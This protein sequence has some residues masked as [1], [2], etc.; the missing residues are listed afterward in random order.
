MWLCLVALSLLL[1]FQPQIHGAL[2]GDPNYTG[3]L[4]LP[5]I[6]LADFGLLLPIGLLLISPFLVGKVIS[7]RALLVYGWIVCYGIAWGLLRETLF[8]QSR[9][10]FGPVWLSAVGS[11][12]AWLRRQAGAYTSRCNWRGACNQ[13]FFGWNRLVRVPSMLCF[14]R[15]LAYL[16]LRISYLPTCFY[17]G[18]LH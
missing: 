1:T 17:V 15:A 12:L 7:N 6:W 16:N 2:L 4:I 18:L 3:I 13:P 14:Q 5:G 9:Q 11:V 8:L 10:N